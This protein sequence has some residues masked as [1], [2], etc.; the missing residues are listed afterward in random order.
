MNKFE[1]YEN[2]V[3]IF[4]ERDKLSISIIQKEAKIGFKL[5]SKVYSE[6]KNIRNFEYR[7]MMFKEFDNMEDIP[8]PIRISKEFDI[9]L[10]LANKLFDDYMDNCR[11]CDYYCHLSD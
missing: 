5:A 3:Q 2:L 8:T 7:I 10:Y 6:W 11:W 9:S 1:K 4:I